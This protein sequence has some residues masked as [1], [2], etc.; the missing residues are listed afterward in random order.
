VWWGRVLKEAGERR[1]EIKVGGRRPLYL[2]LHHH[3]L[4]PSSSSSR[5]LK[6]PEKQRGAND[7]LDLHLC[8]SDQIINEWI[9]QL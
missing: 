1:R 3:H 4:L 9:N 2:H 7:T 5:H 8:V 6:N